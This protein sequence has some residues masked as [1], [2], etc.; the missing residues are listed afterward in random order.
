MPQISE[1]ESIVLDALWHESPLSADGVIA[2][3]AEDNNWTAATV[4]TLLNRLLKKGAVEAD[5][6]GR[7]YLYRPTLSRERYLNRESKGLIDRLFGG[8]VAPLVSHFSEQQQ[9]DEDDIKALRTLLE[10]LDND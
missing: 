8:K 7:R 5:R 1:A 3:V 9:L 4:K 2:A 6:D 10:D